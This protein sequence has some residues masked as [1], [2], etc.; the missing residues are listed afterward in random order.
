MS[1]V[2][3][4]IDTTRRGPRSTGQGR[5]TCTAG[6]AQAGRSTCRSIDSPSASRTP[7]GSQAAK[8]NPGRVRSRC[9]PNGGRLIR[10]W[11]HED[12]APPR[13]SLRV[14]SMSPLLRESRCRSLATAHGRCQY[15]DPTAHQRN[16][17][18]R[19]AAEIV[20]VSLHR[21]R[22]SR[23]WCTYGANRLDGFSIARKLPLS[24]SRLSA[25]SRRIGP[26]NPDQRSKS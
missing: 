26:S 8:A 24:T 11:L 23:A 14:E 19:V 15:D 20:I 3:V 13:S 2:I 21:R 5:R 9:G 16:V 4:A 7:R 12:R 25:R 18:V 6:A 22:R 10:Q 17:S 1:T